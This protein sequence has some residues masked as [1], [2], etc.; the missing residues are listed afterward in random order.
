M[1]L[2]GTGSKEWDAALSTVRP[3]TQTQKSS[4]GQRIAE[5]IKQSSSNIY[6]CA[7]RHHF[8]KRAAN[9]QRYLYEDCHA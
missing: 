1:M 9:M 2:Q 4:W 3:I 8:V 7:P 6:R 5:S